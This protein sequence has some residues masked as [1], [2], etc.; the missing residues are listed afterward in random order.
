MTVQ[1]AHMTDIHLDWIPGDE[2]DAARAA[3]ADVPAGAPIVLTGDI[4]TCPTFAESLLAFAEGCDG[5]TIYFVLGNH[6]AWQGSIADSRAR[7]ALLT[8][9]HP[10]LVYLPAASK[11]V[12]LSPETALVGV[13][14]WYDGRAG[15]VHGS[16]VRLNDWILIEELRGLHRD[17]RLEVLL[18]IASKYAQLAQ[19]ELKEALEHHQHV[20]LAT[21]VPPFPEAA[22]SPYGPSDPDYL[23]WFTNVTLGFQ[24]LA[25]AG[26][27]LDRQITVLCG[28][29]HGGADI[30]VT[31]NL[32]VIT[33][34]AEYGNPRVSGLHAFP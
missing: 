4:A 6:D 12:E 13:N 21:H 27:Y 1:I 31:P 8:R 10:Q 20:I 26:S 2:A 17:R 23:P 14:G 5:R 16:S 30:A 11:I 24:L 19:W 25:T 34:A 32:R 22:V 7:A 15:N 18:D 33:G 3:L 28:H 29:S 9:K